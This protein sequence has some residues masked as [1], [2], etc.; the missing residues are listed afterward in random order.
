MSYQMTPPYRPLYNTQVP[1]YPSP[2]LQNI[3]YQAQTNLNTGHGYDPYGSSAS[4]IA[5]SYS[6]HEGAL[7]LRTQPQQAVSREKIWSWHIF[8]HTICVLWLAP[9]TALLVLNF[10]RHVIGA[11]VWCPGGK[12]SADAFD[13]N[14]I[15]KANR[16]DRLDHNALGGLQF[17]SKALEVW[18]MLIATTLIYDVAMLIAKR[19][20]GLPVGY[21]LTHLEFADIR[22]LFNPLMWTS[23]SPLSN[24]TSLGHVWRKINLYLFAIL[25]TFLTILTNLMG[26][27]T[28]VLV[29]PTLQWI[30]TAYMPAHVFNG[31]GAEYLP[32]GDTLSFPGCTNKTLIQ[33]G[34]YTCTLKVY[35]PSMDAWASIAVSSQRQSELP[36]G[37]LNLGI[38]HEGYF[39][40]TL[41]VSTTSIIIWVPLR[42]V[43][44][45]LSIDLTDFAQTVIGS[46]PTVPKT[47]L[48]NNSLANV[49]QRTGP[50]IGMNIQCY[51]GEMTLKEI[52]NDK[53]VACF[54]G[55]TYD[56]ANYYTKCIQAG[57][58]WG[59]NNTKLVTFSL[60]NTTNPKNDVNVT[61][62]F[63]DKA[64]FYGKGND[65]QTGISSCFDEKS[66]C[67]WE[68]IFNKEMP[69]DMKNSSTNT[70]LTVYQSNSAPTR[71][72][73]IW[74][75]QATY[76]GFPTY[77]FD[78]S[79]SS[80]ANTL[81]IIQ[82]NN[83]T[84]PKP[85]EVPLVVN[86][87]WHL[88]AWSVADGGRVDGTRPMAREL[89]KLIPNLF[90]RWDYKNLTNDQTLFAYLQM[91]SH[92]QSMSLINYYWD[93]VTNPDKTIPQGAQGPVLTRWITIHV[94][95]FGL[96]GR[97]SR[98]GVAVVC[99][100]SFC[101]LLRLSL[102]FFM[103]A[104]NHGPV[105]LFV[106][107]LEHQHQQ[108]F[109][110]LRD[111]KDWAK[112]RYSMVEG[113][114]RKPSFR[115]DRLQTM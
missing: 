39:D 78:T 73:V 91:Y 90:A 93:P 68:K 94:W 20:G 95:A 103:R 76:L 49:L 113:P 3:D 17:V 31:I 13:A 18:F 15:Q 102:G 12:C 99:A 4:L 82:L 7:R 44:R 25:A 21:M 2:S 62:F 14:S 58:G 61:S 55:W 86:P 35:G 5:P 41:N 83:I 54:S 45:Y 53:F 92:G 37:G 9:I 50:S 81:Q 28:A 107:A 70:A 77:K 108:E 63:S 104:K 36:Y 32:G 40:F 29:L 30:D 114:S 105:E 79:V 60:G 48:Y 27:G 65:F 57:T 11:S 80:A 88:A 72:S 112:V 89:T 46:D 64:T 56:N 1:G 101:V 96:S 111:K 42:Q 98:L 71:N 109:V 38:S 19:G 26:P 10:K 115:P 47:N 52:K 6:N 106:A 100:G 69:F 43:V 33:G 59:S 66:N 34:N 75:D 67:D 8:S 22:N 23:P 51:Q 74:C 24:S 85:N 110:G 97:T 87:S 16:L 84:T